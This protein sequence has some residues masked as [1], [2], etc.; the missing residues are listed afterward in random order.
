MG[1][2]LYIPRVEGGV[3]GLYG[4]IRV[5]VRCLILTHFLEA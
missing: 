3:G 5:R 1:G 2:I 4:F